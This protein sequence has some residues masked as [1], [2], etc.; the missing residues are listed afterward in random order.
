MSSLVTQMWL[1]EQY[2]PRLD[3]AQLAKVLGLVRG[4]VNNQISAGTFPIPT[5]V[6]GQRY[7]DFRDVAKHFDDCRKRARAQAA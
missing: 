2:G 4:T 5:Y 1:L 6:D 3:T 7:A